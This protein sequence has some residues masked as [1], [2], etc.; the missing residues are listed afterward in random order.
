[1]TNEGTRWFLTAYK[2]VEPFTDTPAASRI[3]ILQFLFW[4][5]WRLPNGTHNSRTYEDEE[6]ETVVPADVLD[7]SDCS[8]ELCVQWAEACHTIGGEKNSL[9][10]Y[11]PFHFHPLPCLALPCLAAT[12][13]LWCFYWWGRQKKTWASWEYNVMSL[14]LPTVSTIWWEKRIN[15]DFPPCLLW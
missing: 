4:I 11:F 5:Q 7:T 1:M 13:C 9:N 10:L 2:K 6:T 8:Y 12:T 3:R 15:Y 14:F